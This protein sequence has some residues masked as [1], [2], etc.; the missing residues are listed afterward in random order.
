MSGPVS[1]DGN[2]PMPTVVS[3]P[4]SIPDPIDVAQPIMDARSE[5]IS[6]VVEQLRV[7]KRTVEGE[8]MRVRVVTDEEE[9]P[10]NVTLR[11]ERIEVERIPIGRVVESAPPVREEDGV[12]IIPVMEEVV[13]TETR[14]VLKEE[15]H[16]RRIA[17]TREHQQTVL[18]RRQR[19]EVERLP[20]TGKPLADTENPTRTEDNQR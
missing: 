19:A 4:A 7:E 16:V 2:A 12:T 5:V 1:P 11:S 15:L 9:A 20:A 13:V 6:V 17:E 3:R 10:A 14:L 18:L 8:G